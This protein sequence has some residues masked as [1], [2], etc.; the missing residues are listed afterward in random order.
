MTKKIKA[1]ICFTLVLTMLM[2][3]LVSCSSQKDV[4]NG[5]KRVACDGDKFSL[6][7]P[8]AWTDN[9]D[10]GITSAY[11]TVE[12]NAF[13]SVHIA[14]DRDGMT[15]AQYFDACKE[16]YADELSDY[17]FVSENTK[18]SLGGVAAYQLVF[19]VTRKITDSDE[20][21]T[22]ESVA[23]V[24]YKYLQMMA[25]YDGDIYILTFSCKADKYDSHYD[26]LMGADD[27]DGNFVGIIPCFKF[28]DTP[29]SDNDKKISDKVEAPE[30][31]KLASTNKRPY[32]FFVP[33]SWTIDTRSS[34]SAA[35]FSD[36]DKSNVSLQAHMS[37]AQVPNLNTYFENSEIKYKNIYGDNYTLISKNENAKMG[38]I[39]AIQLVFTIK[40]GNQEYRLMQSVCIKGEMYYIFTYTSTPDKFDSH[41]DDVEKMLAAFAVR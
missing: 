34:L 12:E 26:T 8:K 24:Q 2:P 14:E 18:D 32:R 28:E 15:L 13:V 36:G 10:S 20:K 40:S 19:T 4:P 38:N 16:R 30:G 9:T 11:Y 33:E 6:F 25:E 39:D 23:A 22:V 3:A 35:Y 17:A 41:L 29:Y 1:I 31:M 27:D 7:V 21:E 5:Y 37:T